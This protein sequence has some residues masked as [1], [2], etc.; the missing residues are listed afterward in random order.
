M[1]T[2]ASLEAAKQAAELRKIADDQAYYGRVKA[3]AQQ[4]LITYTY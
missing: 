3:A 1:Q 4:P 2:M